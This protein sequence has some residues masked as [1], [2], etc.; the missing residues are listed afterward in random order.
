MEAG[1]ELLSM[2]RQSNASMQLYSKVVKWTEH[3]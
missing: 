3:Y 2:I 1:I